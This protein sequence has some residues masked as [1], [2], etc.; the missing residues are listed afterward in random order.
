[1]FV[2]LFGVTYDEH[3]VFMF[4]STRHML[5]FGSRPEGFGVVYEISCC[6]GFFLYVRAAHVID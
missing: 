5:L 3:F 2:F 4:E 1:V 6:I